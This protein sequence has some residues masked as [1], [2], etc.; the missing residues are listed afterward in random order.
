MKYW[1]P[2][3][4]I[5]LWSG[6]AFAQDFVTTCTDV[7]TADG[8]EVLCQTN[9]VWGTCQEENGSP[10]CGIAYCPLSAQ[11][12]D[13][14]IVAGEPGG[15]VPICE[16]D[17]NVECGSAEGDELVCEIG[18]SGMFDDGD[19]I[20]CSTSGGAMAPSLLLLAVIGAIRRRRRTH[21]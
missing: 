8:D 20:N 3:L 12:S 18:G 11:R 2:I 10:T 13:S 15:C 6:A 5:S 17:F 19:D 21:M 1:L 16:V 14:C 4:M 7:M 9:G